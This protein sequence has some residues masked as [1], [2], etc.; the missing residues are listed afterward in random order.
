MTL[1]DNL[2]QNWSRYEIYMELSLLAGIFVVTIFTIFLTTK[3]KKISL[4]SMIALLLTAISNLLGIFLTNLIFSIT[5]TEVFR[6]IP[7][8]TALL[9][10]SNIGILVGF[11]LSKKDAKNF[12][13]ESIRREYLSDSIKQTVFLILLGSSI[14]LF[15]SVQTK[16]VTSISIL[17]TLSSIWF[18]YWIS[19]YILK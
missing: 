18:T 12:K 17:S 8:I 4:L 9:V 16:S 19:K 7:V 6:T 11:Y 14:F 13:I 15:S 3:S 5:I 2:L 1:I 10:I